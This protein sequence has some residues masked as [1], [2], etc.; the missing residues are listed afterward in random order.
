VTP[1]ARAGRAPEPVR[2]W[3]EGSTS[4]GELLSWVLADHGATC[5]VVHIGGEP[6]RMSIYPARRLGDLVAAG[7]A[8]DHYV[9]DPGRDAAGLAYVIGP[10]RK[11]SWFTVDALRAARYR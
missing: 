8:L 4:L 2:S 9:P 5:A 10:E 1:T 6:A 7:Y 11:G 3:R